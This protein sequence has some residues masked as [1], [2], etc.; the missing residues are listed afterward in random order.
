TKSFSKFEESLFTEVIPQVERDYRVK[1]DRNA[2]AIAG[3][4]MG[5]A[6]SLWIGLNNPD[7]FAWVGSFSA[8]GLTATDLQVSSKAPLSD[9]LAKEFVQ[10]FPGLN[11]SAN[12][13]FHLIWLAC[14]TDDGLLGINRGFRKWLTSEGIK[15][16]S[17][18]T[19]GEHT[20]M[21]WRRNLANFAPLLF[22]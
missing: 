19:P 10:E 9:D 20:W 8:G 17:I 2:R 1:K 7:K 18:E 12:T 15:H 6:Q 11:A 16:T 22:R 14:G 3:L 21:V 13:R 4:S 5:G